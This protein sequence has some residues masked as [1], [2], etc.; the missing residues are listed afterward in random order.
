[1]KK[2]QRKFSAAKRPRRRSGRSPRKPRDVALDSGLSEQIGGEIRMLRRARRMTLQMLASKTGFSVGFLS[3]VERSRSGLSISAVNTIAKAL[4]I[5]LAWFFQGGSDAGNSE[6]RHIVRGRGRKSMAYDTGLV[7]ELLS[8]HLNGRFS[9]FLTRFA[10]KAGSGGAI[11][12]RNGEQAGYVAQG[13]L[14]LSV[15]KQEYRLQA[16]DAFHFDSA[17]PHTY[18]NSGRIEAIVV[19]VV[20][21]VNC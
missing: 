4:G 18:T 12:Q 16:G 19:W 20:S 15:D 3:Q 6:R 5:S 7:D 1:M 17:L 13:E 8:P 21:P 2:R 11:T 14:T 10:P 9:M